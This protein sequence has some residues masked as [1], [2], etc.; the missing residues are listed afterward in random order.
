[1]ANRAATSR[2]LMA[3]A[4]GASMDAPSTMRILTSAMVSVRYIAVIYSAFCLF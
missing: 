3:L 1:M 4:G 2:T